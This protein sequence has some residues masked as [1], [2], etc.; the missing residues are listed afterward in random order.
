M[1]S[2]TIIWTRAGATAQLTH[3]T[4]ESSTDNLNYTPLGNGTAAAS[5]R[6]L[7]GLSL[8]L[9]QHVYIRARGSY[10]TGANNASESIVESVRDAFITLPPAPTQ[11]VSRKLHGGAPF[12]IDSAAHRQLRD[13]MPQR[14]R[15]Q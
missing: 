1:T 7:N 9:S 11:V 4:F 5:S 15:E 13:R 6:M 10:R 8:P 3:V 2:S 12:D 14:R